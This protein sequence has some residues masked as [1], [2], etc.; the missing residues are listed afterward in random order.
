[1][2]MSVR[3]GE[4]HLRETLDSLRGQTFEDF[5][6][7][8][9]DDGS[10]DATPVIL[11]EHD[12]DRLR[13]IRQGPAGL[14]RALGRGLAMAAGEYVAR[15]DADDA[16]L[17]RRIERQIA[18][19][20]EHPDVAL[21]GTWADI[22]DDGGRVLERRRPPVD[23]AAIRAQLLWDNALFHSSW[24]FRR[25]VVEAAGGYDK[26]VER[27]QDYELAWRV[28]RLARLANIPEPLLRWRRSRAA[29]SVTQRDA[30]RRSVGR[31]SY[32]ALTQQMGSA[33]EPDRFWRL[34]ALWDGD[35]DTLEPGD[36]RML[37]RVIERLPAAW[38]RTLIVELVAMA[39]AARPAE[40]VE[41][42][43]AA[44]RSSPEARPRLLLPDRVALILSGP[45]GLR[46]S[47]R[48]RRWLRG[49]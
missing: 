19:L 40:A 17:P 35:R 5:E 46:A 13:V 4:L 26:T 41:L 12:D 33:P 31:T 24:M 27:A 11:A 18:F 6:L 49:Y 21:C 37:T 39:A 20:D 7:L 45:L 9:I 38:G 14:T 48:L 22:V 3:D 47:R 28:S 8:V 44:W 23:D 16:A 42:L 43:S 36:A 29:I 32:A 30:Q 10:I 34:R 2:L 1:M 15:I 25:A